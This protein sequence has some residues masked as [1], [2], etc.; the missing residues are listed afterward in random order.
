MTDP[1]CNIVGSTIGSGSGL[2]SRNVVNVPITAPTAGCAGSRRFTQPWLAIYTTFLSDP[3]HRNLLVFIVVTNVSSQRIFNY[4]HSIKTFE[5]GVTNILGNYI[6]VRGDQH[7][8]SFN[9][10]TITTDT[11]RRNPRRCSITQR[12]LSSPPKQKA[13]QST[14][15]RIA[16]LER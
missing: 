11:Q 2:T 15:P 10:R 16:G 12:H 9:L 13:R 1:T 6:S 4:G 7:I 8:L 14:E 5:V 3:I